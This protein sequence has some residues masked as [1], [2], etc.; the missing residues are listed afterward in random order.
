MPVKH[1]HLVFD[2]DGTLVDSM[3]QWGGKM[4][5]VLNKHGV[6]YPDNIIKILTPLGDVGSAKYFQEELGL[7]IPQEQIIS[8]MDEF[9]LKEYTYNIPAKDAVIDTI[10]TLKNRGHHL[11]VL[12]ASPHRMLD[13]CLKR[14]GIFDIFDNVWSCEDFGT[15]KSDPDIYLA[16][17]KSLGT[18]VEQCTFF[19][20]NL[21]AL[22][23]AKKA[24]MY[25]VGVFDESADDYETDIRAVADMY[26]ESFAELI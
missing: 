17:A 7:K 6:S 19:D 2:F 26:I 25:V 13:V 8:D 1:T 12:T 10:A 9:A 5:H 11:H 4:Y 22:M 14:L 24:G 16:V 3:K 23:T 15:T 21:Y 20:D 18:T